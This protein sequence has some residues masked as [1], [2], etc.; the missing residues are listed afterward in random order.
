MSYVGLS[1]HQCPICGEI[2]TH[3]AE[4]LIDRHLREDAFP[5]SSNEGPIVGWGLCEKHDKL[6]KKGF[7][8]LIELSGDLSQ[9]KMSLE[10]TW[11]NRTGNHV[12]IKRS[13]AQKL[14][15]MSDENVKL[16]LSFCDDA[17]INKL[18]EIQNGTL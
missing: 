12:H 1:R 16:E 6:H 15:N 3:N 4:V 2:H 17:L 9:I 10:S 11:E 7:I 18:E 13:V 5:D 8:C 14:L